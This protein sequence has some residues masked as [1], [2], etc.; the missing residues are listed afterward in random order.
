MALRVGNHASQQPEARPPS[1]SVEPKKGLVL[2]PQ[3][4]GLACPQLC[5]RWLTAAMAGRGYAADL[6]LEAISLKH[7]P[8]ARAW[9]SRTHPPAKEATAGARARQQYQLLPHI[10]CTRCG[11]KYA[12]GEEARAGS[13]L[14]TRSAHS[15]GSS[16]TTKTRARE[17][18]ELFS[19]RSCRRAC[20]RVGSRRAEVRRN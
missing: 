1:R 20:R 13:S 4:A 6:F 10:E 3:A 14:A 7:C 16:F 15:I 5:R 19:L 8:E 17:R 9:R 18:S 2:F 11:C 12:C